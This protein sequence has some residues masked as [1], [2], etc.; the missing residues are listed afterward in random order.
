MT[1]EHLIARTFF[2][3]IYIEITFSEFTTNETSRTQCARSPR[4]HGNVTDLTEVTVCNPHLIREM[5]LV[6]GSPNTS[7]PEIWNG[8]AVCKSVGTIATGWCTRYVNPL[9]EF[10][11]FQLPAANVQPNRPEGTYQLTSPNISSFLLLNPVHC[12]FFPS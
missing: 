8:F 7:P 11:S 6:T 5:V 12:P 2:T 9:F 4:G 1:D 3:L 10:P